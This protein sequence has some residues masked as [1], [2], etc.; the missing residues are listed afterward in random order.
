[1]EEPDAVLHPLFYVPEV[2]ASERGQSTEKGVTGRRP[3]FSFCK[4][5]FCPLMQGS[6]TPGLKAGSSPFPVK[7]QATQ[8]EVGSGQA[9]TP[10]LPSDQ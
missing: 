4:M 1:M 2:S 6:P 9:L 5:L 8:Q 7:N 3:V 10:E